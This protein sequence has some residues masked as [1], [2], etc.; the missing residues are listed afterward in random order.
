[1]WALSFGGGGAKA[2]WAMPRSLGPEIFKKGL[3]LNIYRYLRAGSEQKYFNGRKL[4]F[5]SPISEQ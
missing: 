1:M 3:L 4:F 2:R 5:Q